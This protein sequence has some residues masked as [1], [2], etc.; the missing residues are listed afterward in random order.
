MQVQLTRKSGLC[1]SARQCDMQD[2][3]QILN[4]QPEKKWTYTDNFF[5]HCSVTT[6]EDSE[7]VEW[8]QI[9][10]FRNKAPNKPDVQTTVPRRKRRGFSK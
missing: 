7:K 1:S 6:V 3:L 5:H 4:P 2:K 10:S 9:R 8:K